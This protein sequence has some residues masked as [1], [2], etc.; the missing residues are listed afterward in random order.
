MSPL[1]PDCPFDR[2]EWD[3]KI[4][5]MMATVERRTQYNQWILGIG[6]TVLLAIGGVVWTGL[7]ER[8]QSLEVN[9][10]PSMRERV[11][12]SESEVGALRRDIDELKQGQREILMLL[13]ENP[14]RTR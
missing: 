6:L 5:E 13:R 4:K 14:A 9:G 1:H 10:S 11:S 3:E 8:V 7:T 2:N 12:R